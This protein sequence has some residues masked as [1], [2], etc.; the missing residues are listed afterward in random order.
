MPFQKLRGNTIS[1]FPTNKIKVIYV[2]NDLSIGGA[3]MALYKLLC[4]TNRQRFDPIVISLIDRGALR[5]R[6]EALGISVHTPRMKPGRPNPLALLRLIRL[7]KRH[8]P[9]LIFGDMYHSC[10]A[11]QLAKIVLWQGP[12][13][14]WSI[15]DSISSLATEKNL[16][17]AVIRLCRALSRLPAKI[18]FVSSASQTRHGQFGYY[19]DNSCVIPNGIDIEVFVP[20]WDARASVRSEL[21]LKEDA[22]LIGLTGR[23]H[24]IKDHDNFL[25]AAALISKAHPETHFLL[26]GRGV[27]WQNKALTDSIRELGLADRTH[28]LGERHDSAR[29]AAAVD[30]CSLSSYAESCPIVIGEAMACSVPCVVTDVGDALWMVGETGIVV[31]PRDAK[32]LAAAWKRMIDMGPEARKTL[33]ERGRA[34]VIENFPL[35]AITSRY[36]DLYETVLTTGAAARI[37]RWSGVESRVRIG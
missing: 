24:P 33:G 7:F 12:P 9:D 2:I 37:Q 29:L 20:S 1:N 35:Q 30:I 34:R 15:H 28:L 31:P 18:I 19:T 5:E 25:K 23:Y 10:L 11:V 6:I 22:F 16:T 14:I 13:V 26:T 4:R 27:N 32:A 21:G 8:R 17:A 36:E 3:E